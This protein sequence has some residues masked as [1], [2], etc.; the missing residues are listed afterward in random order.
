MQMGEYRGMKNGKL[1]VVL[2]L[3]GRDTGLDYLLRRSR[4]E[5][6]SYEIVGALTTAPDG[7]SIPVLREWE[8]P[9]RC[10]DIHEFYRQRGAK[11]K[12]L[13]LRPEYDRLSLEMITEFE[14]THLVLY[15]Y[16]YILSPVALQAYP[17]RIINIHDSDLTIMNGDGGPKYRGLHSTRHA[18]LAGETTTCSSVHIATEALD[19]GPILIQS[20]PYPV[21]TEL[22]EQARRWEALDV[23]KAYAYAQREWMM[24]DSWGALMDT[25]LELLGQGKIYV[26]DGEVLTAARLWFSEE[27]V[28]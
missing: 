6:K 26:Q 24:R 27:T 25:T 18:I 7:R 22:V 21:H 23:L 13:S 20:R 16:I 17:S 11:V 15:G 3:A 28:S 9:W 1:R 2:F 12:D 8:I 5:G 14:P 10:N 4:E 19:A